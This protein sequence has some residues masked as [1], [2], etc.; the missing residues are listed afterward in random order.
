MDPTAGFWQR[1]REFKGSVAA[2]QQPEAISAGAQTRWSC[3][4]PRC[5]AAASESGGFIPEKGAFAFLVFQTPLCPLSVPAG[6]DARRWRARRRW[7][8]GRAGS[9]EPRL[10]GA[11]RRFFWLLREAAEE[12]V[13][14]QEAGAR[15][16]AT[17]QSL[18]AAGGISD[19]LL[20]SAA[21]WQE[22]PVL[23]KRKKKKG[24]FFFFFFLSSWGPGPE[25]PSL[26]RGEDGKGFQRLGKGGE[27]SPAHT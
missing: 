10:Q 13:I 8:T 22:P 14:H 15:D 23:G 11:S 21:S 27:P 7:P 9:E 4:A 17:K 5:G 20:M 1:G 19:V 26:P 16:P 12:Y 6:T 3:P 18:C 2:C 25:D 24:F